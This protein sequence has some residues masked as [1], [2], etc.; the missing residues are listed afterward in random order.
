MHEEVVFGH[1]YVLFVKGHQR[2][3]IYVS[4]CMCAY[5]RVCVCVC[6]CAY[7][8]VCMCTYMRVCVLGVCAVTPCCSDSACDDVLCVT[9]MQA[10]EPVV[11]EV[12]NTK[13]PARLLSSL[14][15]LLISAAGTGQIAGLWCR[16]GRP[17]AARKHTGMYHCTLHR[18]ETHG[19]HCTLHCPEAHRCHCTARKREYHCTL[20]RLETHG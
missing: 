15:E 8:R 3:C 17:P 14:L 10:L 6:M 12:F 18:P 4:V 20:H 7:M 11:H 16:V 5:M 19:Y 9:S 1:C 13:P 2:A